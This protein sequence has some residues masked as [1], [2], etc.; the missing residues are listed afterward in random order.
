M[1]LRKRLLSSTPLALLIGFFGIA[2]AAPSPQDYQNA[3]SLRH[4]W[5]HLTRNV[6]FPAT[7]SED[8]K[9][10]YYKKSVENGF[11]WIALNVSDGHKAPAF[12]PDKIAPALSKALSKSI[13]TTD[14][15]IDTFSV[16]PDGKNIYFTVEYDPWSC[17]T[18][19]HLCAPVKDKNR[20]HSFGAVRDLRVPAD[21]T[22]HLSPDGRWMAS[23]QD[24]NLILSK[25][26]GSGTRVL[27]SDGSTGDFYDPE[28]IS[29][30]PN[31]KHLF[32]LR[33]KPGYARFVTRVEAAP[34]DQLQPRVRTQLYSKPGD[35]IDLEQPVL[36]NV[37]S[38]QET[39]LKTNTL[40]NVYPLSS[41]T[42]TADGQ[43]LLLSFIQ[44][45]YQKA[46]ILTVDPQTGHIQPAIEENTNTFIDGDRIFQ[47]PLG[48]NADEIIWASER[49][50]W[51]HLYRFDRKTGRIKNQITTGS[52]VVRD[53]LKVDENK[54]QII[55]G[56]SGMSRDEDPYYV[57]YF[58]INFDGSG[59]TPLTPEKANH[60]AILSPD[61]SLLSDTY[62]RT[63]LPSVSVILDTSDGHIRNIV[64]KGEDHL[65]RQAGFRPPEI[66]HTPGRDH[67]NEIWGIIV[68]PQNYDPTKKYPVIENIYAGPHDSFVPKD[69]W[70]FGYHS[71]GDKVVGMQELADLGFIVVQIDGM[72][73]ANRS[74]AFH[75]VAWKNL[76]DSGFPDRIIWHKA[77]A[78]RDPSYDI[79]RVGIYGGSAGGQ[80]TLNALLFHPEFYKAGVAFAGCYDNRMDKISWNEQW[81]G[82]PVDDSYT[83]ASGVVN[84]HLLQGHL[85]MIVG[86]QDENVDPAST[87][88]VANAL[89]KAGKDFELLVVPGEGHPAGRSEGPIAYAQRKEFGFFV[90]TLLKTPE[91]NWNTLALPL[92]ETP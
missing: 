81:L 7:W 61:G 66:F 38:G 53:V 28:S 1:R 36:F 37:N 20:P 68:R 52:W 55:F 23:V 67:K 21:N 24:N 89:I 83:R 59:L 17:A 69:Y 87:M 46:G 72:G 31:S 25:P 35:R 45:G 47:H 19:G 43:A 76:E 27:S 91:P 88:Q 4:D 49:D 71:G 16:S 77:M 65:L 92:T 2:H 90:R 6:P 5:S 26:D 13:S 39:E 30:S 34:K 58:R 54:K 29:W 44:R 60:H 10:L 15:P 9:S 48:K 80:S 86:E 78:A 62:S 22:P 82:W 75:D 74:R 63:D 57:H 12:D 14:L 85:L 33:V 84:A 11:A 79:S 8:G 50:G 32:I 18:D 73:T 56:A 42:W 51:R 64:E 40:D 70:P 3:L 41:P